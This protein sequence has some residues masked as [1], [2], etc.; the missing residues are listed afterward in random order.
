MLLFVR[1]VSTHRHPEV[2]LEEAQRDVNL[3]SRQIHLISK[4]PGRSKNKLTASQIECAE[5]NIWC[6]EKLSHWKMPTPKYF[7]GV[8]FPTFQMTTEEAHF[9]ASVQKVTES[10]KVNLLQ[11]LEIELL[12]QVAQVFPDHP[13]AKSLARD[14]ELGDGLSL[15]PDKAPLHQ[16]VHA[17]LGLSAKKSQRCVFWT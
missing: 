16:V 9:V 13:L 15:V 4:A 11:D 17:F 1:F 14:E 6:W 3:Q 12:L 8:V 2:S 7:C 10:A 5:N